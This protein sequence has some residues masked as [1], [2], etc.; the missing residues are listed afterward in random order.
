MRSV[1]EIKKACKTCGTLFKVK[2]YRND[3]IYCSHKCSSIDRGEKTKL[4]RPT[5]TC[6]FCGKA[7][8]VPPSVAVTALYCSSRC[9]DLANR[10]K[11][12]QACPVCKRIFLAIPSRQRKYC[13]VSCRDKGIRIRPDSRD[14]QTCGKKFSPSKNNSRYCSIEC[15][16]ASKKRQVTKKRITKSCSTCGKE[17]KALPCDDD[18]RFCSNACAHKAGLRRVPKIELIC[19]TCGKSF[20]VLP[21]STSQL[22]CSQK[23]NHSK[24]VQRIEKVCPVCGKIFMVMPCENKKRIYCGKL[25]ANS[26]LHGFTSAR[27]RNCEFCGQPFIPAATT[28]QRFCTHECYLASVRPAMRTCPVCSQSF[29]P[30]HKTKVYCSPRCHLKSRRN[31][32]EIEAITLLEKIL[33]ESAEC[34]HSF[35][36]LLAENGRHL[37][38][39]AF[40]P[41]S[42][43]AFE[44]DGPQHREYMKIYHASIED[45]QKGQARDLRKE[46][47]LAV[48]EVKLLRIQ[49]SEPQTETHFVERLHLLYN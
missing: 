2:P 34:Q 17:F 6:Q 42:N 20:W 15:S 11:Q 29:F 46:S 49:S 45:F 33:C 3:K 1:P 5:V 38:V 37:Y 10:R 4:N 31:H 24:T 25:C 21:S 30:K 8:Q 43:L 39:D 40:F 41:K 48:H 44:Y 14:C 35:P 23:C 7:F 12:E 27:T 22:Y 47:L 28:N 16:K 19:K 32:A 9:R 36:W 18:R 26:H 13:S